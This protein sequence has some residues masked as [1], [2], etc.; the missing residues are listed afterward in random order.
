MQKKHWV[1][2]LIA[3]AALVASS[4]ACNPPTPTSDPTVTPYA[5]A[6]AEPQDAPTAEP[7]TAE[8]PTSEPQATEEP[9]PTEE[10][11]PP[12][13]N[14][15]PPPT[16]TVTPVPPTSAPTATPEP[17]ATATPEVAAEPLEIVDKGY[18]I[19]DWEALPDSKEWEGHV[20]ITFRGGVP[21]YTSS[22]G[23]RDPQAENV[24]EFRYAAC[25]GA[26]VRADVWSADGQHAF[27][28]L[29]IEAPWCPTPTPTPNP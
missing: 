29:W 16:D 20:E 21:P 4:L 27:R 24:H 9:A 3:L 7:P 11:A 26:P 6:T 28:D 18:E 12:P 10:E 22:V 15:P 13:T 19:L 2:I 1:L 17:T 25:K 5:P 8:P 14:T 23:H